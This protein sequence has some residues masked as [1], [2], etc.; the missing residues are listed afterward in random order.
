MVTAT[1]TFLGPQGFCYAI[2]TTNTVP[3]ATTGY[4][5][6]L[7]DGT[8]VASGSADSATPNMITIACVSG[9]IYHVDTNSAACQG[10]AVPGAVPG[11]S[12]AGSCSF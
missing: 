4:K 8:L 10:A 7:P 9:G 2:Q 6:K 3:A 1:T 5:W 12:T 11:C